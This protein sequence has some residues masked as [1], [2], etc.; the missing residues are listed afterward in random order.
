[1]TI[2]EFYEWACENKVENFDISVSQWDNSMTTM[3]EVNINYA[4]KEV[5]IL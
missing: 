5:E 4:T 2:K 3:I 1:M